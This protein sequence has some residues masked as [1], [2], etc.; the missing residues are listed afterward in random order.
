MTPV[1][2]EHEVV[3]IVESIVRFDSIV[4]S[5]K[6]KG[7][8][9]ILLVDK[10]YKKQLKNA[11]EKMF[12]NDYFIATQN[13]NQSVL[14]IVKENKVESFLKMK[15]F[16][17]D[18]KNG[19]FFTIKSIL[20]I[21][22]KGMGYLI[23]VY[24][25]DAV[26]MS[27][28]IHQRNKILSNILIFLILLIGILYYIYTVQYKRFIQKQNN[29][30]IDRVKEKTKSLQHIALHDAL[31]HLPNR[32]YLLKILQNNL[33]EAK[34]EKQSLYVIFL[35][36][37]RFKEVNDTFG[38]SVGDKLLRKVSRRL[39]KSLRDEDVVARVSGDEF[40][41][42]LKN[43]NREDTIN[44][45]V[46]I[47]AEIQEP[48]RVEKLELF[49]S[50]S[51]GVSHFPTDGTSAK[52]LLRQADT[53]M[54]KA[55]EQGKNNYQFYHRDMTKRVFLR[56]ELGRDLQKALINKE[57]EVYYQPKVDAGSG[58]V[59]GLESLVRW[60]HPEKG[61][62]YPGEFIAL[63][64]EIGLIIPIDEYVREES[65]KQIVTWHNEGVHTG[66]L[67]LNI[68]TKQLENENFL[69]RLQTCVISTGFDI[70]FLEIE[71]LENQ[72]MK[73]IKKGIKILESIKSLGV[74]ISIDDFGTGYSSLSYL[75][76]L[77]IDTLK[78]DRSFI[79]NLFED[80]S[81]IEIVRTIIS[82]AKNLDLEVVAEGVETK[83]Q[84][85][86]L[87]AE[88]CHIIQGYYFT[89]PLSTKE[90]KIFLLQK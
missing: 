70:D 3:G 16:Y 81:S 85:D 44:I 83:E 51:I 12:I 88:S 8:E 64:E 49:T 30:L 89:K 38:H 74:K 22:G 14:K 61:L 10:R 19:L 40:V 60:N 43:T 33:R 4:E 23:L 34:G 31:T 11:S 37:D 21:S 2:N 79:Q 28:V 72:I 65:F 58:K 55:K 69:S 24:P 62:L 63:A 59:L 29:V 57:F 35:D 53:A 76:K 66:T 18:E 6:T 32:I 36:L 77:P 27:S 42:I 87:L 71:V 15:N 47:M 20:S 5:L 73:D 1:F 45:L 39:K 68:S 46:K 41:V 75:Q 9:T 26:D 52:V 48:F 82:L 13:V 56:Q 25:L 50:F 84:L 67:S 7:Y 86:C 17:I 78:I 54:Y 80:Q 90:C